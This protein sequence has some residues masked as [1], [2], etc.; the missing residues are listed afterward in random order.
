MVNKKIKVLPRGLGMCVRTR[1][2][3]VGESFKNSCRIM[4]FVM[5]SIVDKFFRHN[6]LDQN[7]FDLQEIQGPS[8][9]KLY[10]LYQ[11]N[12]SELLENCATCV[13]SV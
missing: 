3:L 8:I 5:H 1:E 2:R 6:A 11:G 12:A 10:Y 7:S 13:P 4:D 9:L